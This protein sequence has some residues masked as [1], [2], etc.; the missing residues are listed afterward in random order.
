M[1]NYENPDILIN[2]WNHPENP[3]RKN[4]DEKSISIVAKGFSNK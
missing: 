1:K 4:D 3:G 2:L